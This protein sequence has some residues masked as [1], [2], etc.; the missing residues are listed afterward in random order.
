MNLVIGADHAGY[1]LKATLLPYLLDQG[2]EVDDIGTYSTDAVDYPDVAHTVAMRVSTGRADY[3]ILICGS[4][5]GV[6]ITANKHPKV[7]AGI[8]WLPELA[9]LTRQH[10]DANILCLPARYISVAD[11]TTCC[12]LFIKTDFEGG[13]H[14]RRVSKIPC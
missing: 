9:V 13:R 14:D 2:H 3:G 7:R 5:N 6:A 4:A 12:D 8:A 1:E 10:N 11:A